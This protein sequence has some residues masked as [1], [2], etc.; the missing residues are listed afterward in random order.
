MSIEKPK[1]KIVIG[2][3]RKEQLDAKEKIEKRLREV[4]AWGFLTLSSFGLVK[5]LIPEKPK[6]GV[7]LDE[8][9]SVHID[10]DKKLKTSERQELYKKIDYLRQQFGDLTVFQLHYFSEAKADTK[11]KNPPINGFNKLHSKLD[12]SMLKRI[13]SEKYYPKDWINERVKEIKYVESEDSIPVVPDEYGL[14]P[15]K[16]KAAAQFSPQ[17]IEKGKIT[18][19]RPAG[20]L[21]EDASARQIVAALDCCFSHE[22][23]HANDWIEEDLNFKQRVE[24]FYD[25][26]RQCF[27]QGRLTTNYVEAI[28]NENPQ[29]ERYYKTVEYWAEM[30]KIYFGVPEEFKKAD[31]EAFAL[32][33]KYVKM[34][35]P[36]YNCVEKNEQKME[37]INKIAEK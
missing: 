25:V 28:R 16:W 10:K 1:F 5:A 3:K 15:K 22:L 14:D 34:E 8:I 29:K 23:G 31:P 24:F 13:W 4:A 6:Q 20:S 27:E 36:K 35:D 9:V 30:C 11:P 32:V 17:P 19:F 18:F 21:S 12:D 2:E 37:A 7:T 26:S 33:D